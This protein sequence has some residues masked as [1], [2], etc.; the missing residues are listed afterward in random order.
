[1]LSIICVYN[2]KAVLD[3]YLLKS[4]TTQSENYEL[5]LIDNVKG[6]F[7]SAPEALNYG[8]NKANGDYLMF[9]HQDVEL[10]SNV[11][12]KDIEK[13][14]NTLDNCGIAG[15]AGV[16][17]NEFQL[18]SNIQNGIPPMLPGDEIKIP[19]QVQTLDECLIIIPKSVF[20]KYKFDENLVG[21]H[22]YSVDYCLN[23]KDHGFKVYVIPADVYHRSYMLHYPKEYYQILEIIFK[24]HRDRYKKIHTS[25][26]VWNTSYPII[27]YIFLNTQTGSFIKKL[28]DYYRI[29]LHK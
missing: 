15:V 9:V 27:W 25:C 13:I 2:D 19:T 22:L 26:G 7:K 28:I 4:L 10:K 6:K 18:K 29:K 21:W 11:L 16:P 23:I 1:M 12:L 5:I 3:E 14:M 24:K 17:E 20:I 8:G